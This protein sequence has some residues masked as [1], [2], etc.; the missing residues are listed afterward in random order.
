SCKC[1]MM[2]R[3]WLLVLLPAACCRGFVMWLQAGQPVFQKYIF[4]GA[5]LVESS[6]NPFYSSPIYTVWMFLASYL[7][8]WTP[9]ILRLFQLFAGLI[10]VF[11]VTKTTHLLLDRPQAM[12]A[13]WLFGLASPVIVYESDLVTASM[14][15]AIQ[16]LATWLLISGLNSRSGRV[17]L[18]LIA[19]MATGI[20]IGIRPNALLMLPFIVVV[21]I[22]PKTSWQRI[23]LKTITF[24]A[25]VF[26]FVAPITTYNYL[27]TKEF[28]PVTASG[29]SVFY[30]SNNFRATGLGYSPPTSLTELENHWMKNNR[31]DRP[32]EHELFRYLACR[33]TGR[34]LDHNEISGFYR[35]EGWKYLQ[36]DSASGIWFWMRKLFYTFNNYEV[37]DT[38]SLVSASTRI[39]DVLP[40]L[41]PGGVIIV[42]GLFGLRCFSYR[43]RRVWILLVFMFPHIVTGMVFYVNGRLRVP[44]L[45][46][47]AVFAGAGCVHLV[48]LIRSKDP[49]VWMSLMVIMGLAAMVGYRDA[50][51][52][53]HAMIET[54][55]FLNSVKGLAAIK[56]GEINQAETF[57]SMAVE[58]NPLG[59]REAWVG[60]ADIY[61]RVDDE[62]RYKFCS[63][64]AAGIWN[65]DEIDRM[66]QESRFSEYEI[67]MTRARYFWVFDDRPRALAMFRKAV[68]E[69]PE[70]P[71]PWYNCAVAFASTEHDWERVVEY[72]E[73]ALNRGMKFSLDS[74]RAHRLRLRGYEELKQPEQVQAV[75]KQLQWEEKQE[76]Y[77]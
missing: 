69:Y 61:L 45:Y 42:L 48:R 38:A 74:K 62:L 75:R 56:S 51:I 53:H 49:S 15:I 46:F 72:A 8:G 67:L 28:I 21:F 12:A 35:G 31:T 10:S 26:L 5:N 63:Q 68:R 73:E 54:P 22:T 58:A 50:G 64:R 23:I 6:S 19:G 70:Y 13:G 29:G 71:D 44:L 76:F 33:A 47:F 34:D 14:V 65:L 16:A 37:L 77:P 4:L 40:F 3:D 25:G 9:D 60:L 17:C 36:R 24:F 52:Q 11:L 7:G 27:K 39:R 18:W 55:A 59:A 41:I 2:P 66:S 20:S 30:S 57:F 43:D 1:E 32:V